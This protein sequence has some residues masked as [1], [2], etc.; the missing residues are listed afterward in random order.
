MIRNIKTIT[1]A[2]YMSMFF[3]GVSAALIGAAAH[4]I[5]LSPFQIG[6]MIAAQNVGFTVSVVVSGALSD[7]YEKPKILLVG[8]LILAVAYFTFYLDDQFW[9]NLIIMFFIG[10]GIGTYEGVADALLFEIHTKRQSL[11]INVNHFFVTFGAIMIALYL[12]FLQADWRNSGSW[13]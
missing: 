2:S 5:G 7:Q 1:A 6:L 8:S 11:H 9:L 13:Y 4:N 10:A 3:L 12:T